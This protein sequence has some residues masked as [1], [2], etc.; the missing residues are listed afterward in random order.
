LIIFLIFLISQ[1]ETHNV[2]KDHL[3]SA[4]QLAKT[5]FHKIELKILPRT[6]LLT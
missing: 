4:K 6:N 1:K 3:K 2:K 5:C